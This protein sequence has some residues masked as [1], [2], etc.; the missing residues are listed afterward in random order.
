MF[1]EIINCKP[2]MYENDIDRLDAIE[3]F[4]D[5]H[6]KRKHIIYCTKNTCEEIIDCGL[7]GIRQK[8]FADDLYNY[9]REFGSIRNIFK[10]KLVVDF[11]LD[12]KVINSHLVNDNLIMTASYHYLLKSS[13]KNNCIFLAEDQSDCDFYFLIAKTICH[14]YQGGSIGI[15]LHHLEGGGSRTHKK[16]EE[17]IKNEEFSICIV[18]NDKKHPLGK[19]GDTS[20]SFSLNRNQRGYALNQEC[21]VL[22]VHEAECLIPDSILE[23]VSDPSKIDIIDKIR[24]SD[25]KS[26]YQFRVYFDHKNG[27]RLDQG[28]QLDKLYKENFWQS[29]FQHDQ[30]YKSKPCIEN[31][32]CI[33]NTNL[34]CKS[35]IEI[36]GLGEKILVQ[37]I[38]KM[39]KIHL[40]SIYENSTPIIKTKWKEIGTK[41][42]N[43]GCSPNLPAVR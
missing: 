2:S 40:R 15:K 42:I 5:A 33:N 27:F 4:L 19:E 43:W 28:L 18:D 41:L 11:E 8:K 24:N 38:E 6:G 31:K 26:D 39:E 10:L 25:K 32:T 34:E 13:F 35:C 9:K 20:K 22:D 30:A 17:I 21:I 36:Y 12:R 37:S 23:S 7:F 16:Y 14:R 3:S 1:V 29:I